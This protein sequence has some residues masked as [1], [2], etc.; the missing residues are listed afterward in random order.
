M[1]NYLL[2]RDDLEK[3]APDEPETQAK[4]IEVMSDGMH[5]VHEKM[6]RSVRVSHAKAHALLEGTLTVYDGLPPELAQGLFAHPA[7]YKVLVRMAQAPG[8]F[9]DDSKVQPDRGM[10]VKVLGVE[11]KK[12]EGDTST[13][14]D[15]VFDVGKQ[16]IAGGVK[17][18]LQAFK[19]NAELAP[20]LSQSV[21]GA[22]STAARTANAAL[23]AVGAN[24]EKLAFYGHELKHPLA[25]PYFSQTPYRYGEYVAKLG[26]FPVTPG[27]EKLEKE[28]LDPKTP[29][30][31]RDAMTEFFQRTPAEFEMR[32]QLNTGEDEM[33]IEDAQAN[34]PETSSQYQPVAKLL[35]PVQTA[36]DERKDGYFEYM[37]FSPGHALAAHRPLGGMNRARLTVYRARWPSAGL[38]KTE[39]PRR[40]RRRWR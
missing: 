10:S 22:V 31:L 20:K 15:W 12:I 19:P 7:T 14:Q 28:G 33:P 18:F 37:S 2:Y 1:P 3:V 24:S 32:V 13:V 35:L 40:S 4:I 26:F 27:I 9:L 34:W 11:G 6:G 5:Q 21:K 8:E 38:R 29:N 30:G 36:W 25:E 39:G 23:Q 17:E 16:F